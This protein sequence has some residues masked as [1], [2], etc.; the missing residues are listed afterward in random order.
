MS[1]FASTALLMVAGSFQT[2]GVKQK[3]VYDAPNAKAVPLLHPPGLVARPIHFATGAAGAVTNRIVLGIDQAKAVMAVRRLP[4]YVAD[5]PLAFHA[6]TWIA[7]FREPEDAVAAANALLS[8]A[9]IRYAHPDFKLPVD[10]RSASAPETEPLFSR[11]WHLSNTGQTGGQPGADIGVLPAWEKTHGSPQT[12]VAMIDLGFEQN[13]PDLVEAWHINP[14]EIAGNRQDD[15]H[16]GLKDDVRGWNFAID[17][18]NLIYGAAPNHGTCTSGIVGARANGT[19]VSGVC[20]DCEILPVVIDDITSNAAKGIKYA[21]S[22]G[23]AV[24]SNSWGYKIGTPQTD[25]VVEAINDAAKNGRGGLGTSIIFAMNNA[26]VDD[27]RN[28]DIS[29]LPNVIAVSSIDHADVRVHESGFGACLKFLAPTSGSQA[30]GIA[31]VD[32]PGDKG[33]NDGERASDFADL[34]YTNTFYGTSAA[35]P[36]VAGAF[37][38]LYALHPE[39]SSAE[40]LALFSSTADKADAEH[41]QYD[42]SG[43]SNSHGFGRINVGRAL[44][45]LKP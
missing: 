24:M 19:G 20:P 43:H 26:H 16:N 30:N 5:E 38:L 22:F 27:C 34:S 21:Q 15:D 6:T 23:V 31:T 9:G 39:M 36:Q 12:L 40:A 8:V 42:A 44:Q 18:T 13:H 35:A 1:V 33:Y 14:G 17:G 37:A 41:A 11:Q 45:A 10:T 25:V 7:T 2:L 29:S 3:F 28:R 32:R 4:G